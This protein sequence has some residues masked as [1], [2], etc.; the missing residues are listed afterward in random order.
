MMGG[1]VVLE[2]SRVR[3]AGGGVVSSTTANKNRTHWIMGAALT[4]LAS[5]WNNHF[6]YN[7][8]KSITIT[9]HTSPCRWAWHGWWA[10]LMTE[11]GNFSYGCSDWQTWGRGWQR[12]SRQHTSSSL[13]TWLEGTM[14]WRQQEEGRVELSMNLS[15][16]YASIF[17]LCHLDVFPCSV[18]SLLG[19]ISIKVERVTSCPVNHAAFWLVEAGSHLGSDSKTQCR[20]HQQ[21]IILV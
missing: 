4:L 8:P 12:L 11:A 20:Q 7:Y 6:C 18:I 17:G 21:I 14:G 1:E 16:C 15:A 3:S 2:G 13:T 19:F 10:G 9:T 5:L